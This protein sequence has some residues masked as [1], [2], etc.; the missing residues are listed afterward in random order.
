[1]NVLL[2]AIDTLRADHLGCYGYGKPTSPALDRF[3][4]QGVRAARFMAP[5]IPTHP[6]F[7]TLV[8]GQHPIRHGIVAQGSKQQ[9]SHRT[10]TLAQL[11]L[12][13]GYYTAA[14][15]N[16]PYHKEHFA[17]GYEMV[18][19]SSRRRGC[20]LMVMCEEINT[21]VRQFL[22]HRAADREP[23]FGFVHYWDPH[24][25]Y[26]APPRY[27]GLFY[28]GD[29]C[30]P[31]KHSLEALYEHPL[32]A[33]WKDTWLKTVLKDLGYA[34]DAT[35]T[36]AD[37]VSALYDQE[38]R[39]IDDGLE[40]VF[41]TLDATGLADETLVL[42]LGDHGECLVE[43][44]IQFDHHGLYDENL[45]VP[46]LA[47]LPGALPAGRTVDALVRHL[48]VLPTLCEA[49]G[50]A[51]P[52]PLDGKSAW[53]LFTGS[54]PGEV[55]AER[56]ISEE[57]SWQMKWSL[58]DADHHFILARQE[59]WYGSPMRE[60]YDVKADPLLTKNVAE[61]RPETVR[62]LERDLEGWIADR[63]KELNLPGD[64]LPAH[65]I[66]MLDPKARRKARKRE[67]AR[68]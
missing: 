44:G 39:H 57:C 15:D 38:I 30:D 56:L 10:Q 63:C 2:L 68:A 66:T 21:R 16:L 42:V 3:A 52:E 35:L 5:G 60:L 62:E 59:D 51:P 27:R 50:I 1:M 17:R 14:F 28:E 36:D 6:S 48:D 18:V 45:H 7:T 9:L 24:T 4:R 67:G 20:G 65:G 19:D 22:K 8:T 49:C 33:R 26:W 29:P 25:P 34:E 47:R 40:S 11:F 43:H 53:G 46:L 13:A 32:G 41:E 12:N 61:A 64:P 37:F 31:A 58:R 54:R 23:F 55:L